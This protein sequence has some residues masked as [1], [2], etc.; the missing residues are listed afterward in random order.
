[1]SRVPMKIQM[2]YKKMF[3]TERELS[4]MPVSQQQGMRQELFYTNNDIH[5]I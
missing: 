3:T 2:E 1:M 4:S 5:N